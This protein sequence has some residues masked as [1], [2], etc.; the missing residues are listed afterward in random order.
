M[1]RGMLPVAVEAPDHLALE[2]I[3]T[4]ILGMHT[5]KPLD[6]ESVVAAPQERTAIFPIEEHG[7]IEGLG[8]PLAEVQAATNCPSPK[9]SG[10][11]CG[12]CTVCSSIQY[13][14]VF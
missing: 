1:F 8:A 9:S 4:S 14:I 2:G 3:R 10:S 7:V 12:S 6:N 11:F 5:I 13:W